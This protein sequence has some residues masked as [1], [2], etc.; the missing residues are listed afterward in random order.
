MAQQQM[1]MGQQQM[2]AI[3]REMV[4]TQE[5]MAGVA[6]TNEELDTGVNIATT[7]PAGPLASHP[8]LAAGPPAS[9]TSS[10]LCGS[11]SMPVSPLKAHPK[12]KRKRVKDDVL[13]EQK[14]LVKLLTV[15]FANDQINV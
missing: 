10:S 2:A 4:A 3:Q 14:H 7:H 15:E 6:P 13:L 8:D 1:V 12:K 5:M 11:S 9:S